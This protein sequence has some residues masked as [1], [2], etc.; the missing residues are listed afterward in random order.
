[1]RKLF[2]YFC[3]TTIAHKKKSVV[4]NHLASSNHKLK[5]NSVLE[6]LQK[7][8]IQHTITTFISDIEK[9]YFIL[10]FIKIFAKADILLEKIQYFQLF[11]KNIVNM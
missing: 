3:Q 4:E 8:F 10:D 7:T 2:C 1:W 5:K 9:E 6:K 11:Y